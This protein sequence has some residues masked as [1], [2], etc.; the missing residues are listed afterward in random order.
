MLER[1]NSFYKFV[2]HTVWDFILYRGILALLLGILCIT[3]PGITLNTFCILVGIFLLLNG[4]AA[5]LKAM[6]KDSNKKIHLIYGFAFLAAGIIILA[7]QI[8]AEWVLVVLFS[9]WII[10]SGGN[11]LMAAWKI[12]SHPTPARIL[13]GVTGLISVLLGL[14]L[15]AYPRVGLRVIIMIIGIYFVT[16]GI[17]AIATGSVI[18]RAGKNANTIIG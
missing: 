11:E 3:I 1:N 2:H 14:M 10:I 12:K 16:F 7:Y 8:V 6:K 5:L 9:L 18:H 4:L 13:T 15:L 17:L